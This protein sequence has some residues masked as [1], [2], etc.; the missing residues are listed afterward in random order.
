MRKTHPLD[1]GYGRGD[2]LSPEV[3][4]AAAVACSSAALTL[5]CRIQR[6]E[7]RE[8]PDDKQ[9]LR[10]GKSPR[11]E[12]RKQAVKPLVEPLRDRVLRF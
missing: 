10:S 9:P 7:D 6:A 8:V 12:S 4:A 2:P 1:K 11:T 3:R 5:R